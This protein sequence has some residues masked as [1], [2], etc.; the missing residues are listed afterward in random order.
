MLLPR[1]DMNFY[2]YDFLQCLATSNPTASDFFTNAFFFFHFSSKIIEWVAILIST[3]F[4]TFKSADGK[5]TVCFTS[6]DL[7]CSVRSNYI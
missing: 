7:T 3:S 1:V 2:I 4:P 5:I 6:I